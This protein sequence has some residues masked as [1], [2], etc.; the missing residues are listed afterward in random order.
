M[1]TGDITTPFWIKHAKHG[2]HQKPVLYLSRANH[3][4]KRVLPLPLNYISVQGQQ[5]HLLWPCLVQFESHKHWSWVRFTSQR[6][7]RFIFILTS[8]DGSRSGLTTN[9]FGC[10]PDRCSRSAGRN[11]TYPQCDHQAMETQTV[12]ISSIFYFPFLQ[13]GRK[14][15]LHLVVV[16]YLQTESPQAT[17]QPIPAEHWS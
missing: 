9:Q 15:N 17:T 4:P 3:L 13:L 8:L 10:D 5:T 12:V 7:W 1:S 14:T 2:P 11:P 6:P 16:Y